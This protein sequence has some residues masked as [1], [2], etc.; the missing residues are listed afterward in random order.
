MQALSPTTMSLAERREIGVLLGTGGGAQDF[1][2]EQYKLYLTGHPKQVSVYSVS[3]GTMGTLSSEL[4]MR[5]GFRGL[6]RSSRPPV[7]LQPMRSATPCATSGL[8][9][10]P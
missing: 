3:N 4:S 6:A 5:F 2:E 10:F 8:V 9:W 7:L 1:T